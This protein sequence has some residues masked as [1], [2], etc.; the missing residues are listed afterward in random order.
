[1]LTVTVSRQKNG[2]SNAEKNWHNRLTFV[3]SNLE[4]TCLL[5]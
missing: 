3:I 5:Y 4:F 1:M 2:R